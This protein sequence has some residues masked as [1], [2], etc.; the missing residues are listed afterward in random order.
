MR[1]EKKM[2]KAYKKIWEAIDLLG[3]IEKKDEKIKNTIANMMH[4]CDDVTLDI[5]KLMLFNGGL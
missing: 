5:E 4:D 3:A 1:D 2:W